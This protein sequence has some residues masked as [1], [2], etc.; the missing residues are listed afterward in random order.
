[1][2]ANELIAL[3]FD[4]VATLNVTE[5]S[6]DGVSSKS[7]SIK[8][9]IQRSK[10]KGTLSPVSFFIVDPR[11]VEILMAYIDL[12]ETKTGRF[13]RKLD[14]NLKPMN[15]PIGISM[16]SV[17]AREIAVFLMLEEPTEF[18]SHSFRHSGATALADQGLSVIELQRAGGWSSAAVAE[19][20][21]ETNDNARLK[22]ARK[23]QSNST[24]VNVP[25]VENRLKMMTSSSTTSTSTHPHVSINSNSHCTINLNMNCTKNSRKKMKVPSTTSDDESS[26]STE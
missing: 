15:R 3:T 14:D 4:Q 2:R 25:S 18:S 16:V 19:S 21:V 10:H 22:V 17:F 20:Y 24:Q 9:T 8:I 26:S 5:T 11:C 23:L 1:L 7:P 12:Y 13:F 6:P